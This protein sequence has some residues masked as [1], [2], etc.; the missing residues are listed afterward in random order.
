[1]LLYLHRHDRQVRDFLV[2]GGP[3]LLLLLGR[4]YRLGT[5]TLAVDHL[6][7]L[8]AHRARDDGILALS[9][10]RLEDVPL[11]GVHGAADHGLAKAVGAG[12][13][14]HV[15]ETTLG[16]QREHHSGSPGLAAH[17]LL[18]RG[19]ELDL[20]VLKATVVAVGDG[21]VREE[22]SEDQV[23]L[24]LHVLVAHDVQ[25]RLL[26]AREGGVRQ[27]LGGRRGAHGEGEGVAP[28]A[29]ALPLPL[30]FLFEVGLERRVHD[31]VPDGLPHGHELVHVLVDGLVAELLV[32]EIV[33]STLVEELLVGESCGAETAG[34]WHTHV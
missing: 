1:M 12:Y 3:A 34:H 31:L 7:Q 8:R 30:E 16:V 13:E 22:R 5:T 14:D 21:A 2:R 25:V 24:G 23:H 17:H 19:T 20:G 4:R 32:D 15:P 9:K 29:H 27:V 26:L 6:D 28:P 10:S 18:A 11:V 33:D